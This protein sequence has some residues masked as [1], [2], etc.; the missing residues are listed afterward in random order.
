M[1]QAPAGHSQPTVWELR[2]RRRARGHSAGEPLSQLSQPLFQHLRALLQG[3]CVGDMSTNYRSPRSLGLPSTAAPLL[4]QPSIPTKAGSRR[5]CFPGAA[6]CA[7]TAAS[8]RPGG[9]RR[10]EKWPHSPEWGRSRRCTAPRTEGRAAEGPAMLRGPHCA[11]HLCLP[12]TSPLPVSSLA[13]CTAVR[14]VP[15]VFKSVTPAL[16]KGRTGSPQAI[17]LGGDWQH[18][19]HFGKQWSIPWK[20]KSAEAERLQTEPTR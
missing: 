20:K 4:P 17:G 19:W 1:L 16:Q 13:T 18:H 3:V 10:P 6:G 9:L 14:V 11:S 2:G 12:P 7:Q 15:R 5:G 8:R